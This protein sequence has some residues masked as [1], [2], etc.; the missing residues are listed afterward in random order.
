MLRNLVENFSNTSFKDYMDG[1]IYFFEWSFVY[2][3]YQYLASKI[4]T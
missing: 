1:V 2:I 4:K 3:M